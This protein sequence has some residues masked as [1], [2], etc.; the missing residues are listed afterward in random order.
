M[1]A[2]SENKPAPPPQMPNDPAIL[3][4]SLLYFDSPS[5]HF[6]DET[7]TDVNLLS[8]P[9]AQNLVDTFRCLPSD[10]DYSLQL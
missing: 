7:L 10:F 6:D 4:V 1:E 9:R 2:P 8:C 3:G 5:P